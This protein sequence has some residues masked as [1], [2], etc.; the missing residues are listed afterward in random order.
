[1]FFSENKRFFW[2]FLFF[3]FF[4]FFSFFFFSFLEV[5]FTKKA[6]TH[7]LNCLLA[8]YALFSFWFRI[9]ANTAP[10]PTRELLNSTNCYTLYRPCAQPLLVS[11]KGSA[12]TTIFA[13]K[14]P[15]RNLDIVNA[16]RH[17]DCE[18]KSHG[19]ANKLL[20]V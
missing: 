18:V 14:C 19:V 1:M 17:L 20:L 11:Y 10:Q 13:W 12:Y 2:F 6:Y 8:V 15:H 9:L 7:V 3:F 5:K 4:F 16:N